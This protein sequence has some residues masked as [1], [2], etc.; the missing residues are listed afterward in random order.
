MKV[1]QTIQRVVLVFWG[2]VFGE[3]TFA[4][5]VVVGEAGI[6]VMVVLV[7]TVVA[8]VDVDKGDS[9]ELSDLDSKASSGKKYFKL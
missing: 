8:V 6:V 5:A 9:G 1:G 3:V 7:V 4:V 2:F